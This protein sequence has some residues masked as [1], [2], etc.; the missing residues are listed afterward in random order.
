MKK[1]T[2]R[3]ILQF[4]FRHLT[5]LEYYNLENIPTTG[6]IILATNHLSRLDIPLL[7][8]NP[9]RSDTTAL[10][11]DKYLHYP[12]FRWFTK[13]AGGIWLDREHADFAAISTSR[14]VL[15]EGMMLGIAP[16]GT[17]SKTKELLEGKPG[18][19]L[20]ALRSGAP[21]VPTGLFGTED[22]MSQILT[23]RRPRII[24]RIGKPFY[25]PPLDRETRSEQLK[26]WTDELMLR[27]AALLPEKY[28]GFYR[29]NPRIKALQAEQGEF[30]GPV[31]I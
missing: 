8:I 12:I 25:I 27:I 15:K 19:I 14:E 11:T 16:E 5:R 9:V 1:E 28:H 30:S 23:L 20:I 31:T 22:S 4:L 2:L 3:S 21:I 26:Y 29:G 13:T 7:L 17:R 24:V 6:P 18:T 10:V